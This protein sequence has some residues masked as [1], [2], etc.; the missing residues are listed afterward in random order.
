MLVACNI[1][2]P[3]W[4]NRKVAPRQRRV[5]S[6]AL[7]VDVTQTTSAS[8][9]RVGSWKW[10]QLS[11]QWSHDMFWQSI[12]PFKT[13]PAA[14]HIDNVYDTCIINSL[15]LY[16]IMCTY[17]GQDRERERE[18]VRVSARAFSCCDI[19]ITASLFWNQLSDWH[20]GIF[21]C[22]QRVFPLP[23]R[24]KSTLGGTK[25]DVCSMEFWHCTD[26]NLWKSYFT[27]S[28]FNPQRLYIT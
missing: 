4:W 18:G 28:H 12:C 23:C 19:V 1:I 27:H 13:E 24:G 16:C 25:Q 10:S 14:T 22:L 6:T 11:K 2:L 5:S 17:K 26:L 9:L 15:L 8:P 20:L 21:K 7:M 3:S